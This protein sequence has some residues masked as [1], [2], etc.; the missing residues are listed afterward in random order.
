MRKLYLVDYYS[1]EIIE[2]EEKDGLLQD[3]KGVRRVTLIT[4]DTFYF[5]RKGGKYHGRLGEP[6]SNGFAMMYM[7]EDIDDAYS[8]KAEVPVRQLAK[9]VG[10]ELWK[11][12]SKGKGHPSYYHPSVWLGSQMLNACISPQVSLK[13]ICESALDVNV[14]FMKDDRYKPAFPALYSIKHFYG[15]HYRKALMKVSGLSA[16]VCQHRWRLK[17]SGVQVQVYSK[18]HMA[19]LFTNALGKAVE[20]GKVPPDPSQLS[21]EIL[22]P[23]WAEELPE[24]TAKYLKLWEEHYHLILLFQKYDCSSFQ[25]VPRIDI[26]VPVGQTI[27]PED[28]KLNAISKISRDG[29]V[30]IISLPYHDVSND[31]YGMSVT[32]EPAMVRVGGGTYLGVKTIH[33][34]SQSLDTVL[35]T[36]DVKKSSL[37]SLLSSWETESTVWSSSIL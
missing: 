22:D 10:I 37:E 3:A 19:H 7:S 25:I 28:Y 30:E 4:H 31:E 35:V 20:E 17:R 32:S 24:L 13:R 34:Q 2:M 33:R 5:H 26:A 21:I 9:R 14:W 11:E 8:H 27:S 29:R 1:Q 18:L 15:K 6:F 12:H 36:P 16:K 23:Q